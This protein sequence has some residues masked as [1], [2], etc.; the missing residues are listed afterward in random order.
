MVPGGQCVKM[1]KYAG[2]LNVCPEKQHNLQL[3]GLNDKF[4]QNS[5][6]LDGK[7]LFVM[8]KQPEGP[9]PED[10]GW[11]KYSSDNSEVN[12][13]CQKIQM[14]ATGEKL[15]KGVIKE[16]KNTKN[17]FIFVARIHL[18]TYPSAS[19]SR[20]YMNTSTSRC[21]ICHVGQSIVLVASVSPC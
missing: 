4:V 19:V 10:G 15:I 11:H 21:R 20:T 5:M 3:C 6:D 17:L 13:N 16:C 14:I 7:K 12:G 8:C 18:S 9:C 2:K 1:M